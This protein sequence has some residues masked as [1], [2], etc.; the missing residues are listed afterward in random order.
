MS[1]A[2]ATIYTTLR[3]SDCMDQHPRELWFP[4][5]VVPHAGCHPSLAE[6]MSG[7]VF[8]M[9]FAHFSLSILGGQA[10]GVSIHSHSLE[11]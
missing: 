5:T 9:V 7:P 8:W 2:L 10:A 6:V 4:E 11:D 3:Q 1:K